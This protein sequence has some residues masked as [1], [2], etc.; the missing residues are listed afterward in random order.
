VNIEATSVGIPVKNKD[1]MDVKKLLS[2][3]GVR[4][5]FFKMGDKMI[6]TEIN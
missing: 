6:Y 2:K 5:C 4:H 3:D 1:V